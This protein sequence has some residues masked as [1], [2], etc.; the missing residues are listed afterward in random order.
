MIQAYLDWLFLP[1]A[2]TDVIRRLVGFIAIP[3]L[4]IVWVWEKG[5]PG[6]IT[7]PAWRIGG[8]LLQPPALPEPITHSILIIAALPGLADAF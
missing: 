2:L 7:V 5:G 4:L 8:L 1:R 6:P 3:L